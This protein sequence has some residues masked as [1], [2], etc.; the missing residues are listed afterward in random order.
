MQLDQNFI[1]RLFQYRRLKKQQ[2]ETLKHCEAVLEEFTPLLRESLMKD[3]HRHEAV[4]DQFD[5]NLI[6]SKLRALKKHD[7]MF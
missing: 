6:R 5:L 2:L 1:K 4:A 3:F 7:V